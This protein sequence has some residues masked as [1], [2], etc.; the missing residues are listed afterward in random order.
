MGATR[1]LTHKNRT[2]ILPILSFDLTYITAPYVVSEA[3]A[4]TWN[5][6]SKVDVSTNTFRGMR[7]SISIFRPSRKPNHLSWI[8]WGTGLSH[9]RLSFI[10]YWT[11]TFATTVNGPNKPA[12]PKNVLNQLLLLV[13][14]IR[15]T[16][17]TFIEQ[18]EGCQPNPIT[19]IDSSLFSN[20]FNFFSLFSRGINSFSQQFYRLLL[21]FECFRETV[22]SC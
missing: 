9:S 21:H 14:L 13:I 8:V 2:M 3:S 16:S 5:Y 15:G 4:N 19:L 11:I 22:C 10:N 7:N 12:G 17:C 20:K 6:I 1:G 18:F